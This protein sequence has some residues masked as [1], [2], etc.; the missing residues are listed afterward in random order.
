[1]KAL[2]IKLKIPKS[3]SPYN[4]EFVAMIQQSD[5]DLKNRKGKKVTLKE[6]EDLWK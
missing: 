4:S 3:K 2:K 1:M 5:K 6:L